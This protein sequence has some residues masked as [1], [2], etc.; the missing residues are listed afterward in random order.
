MKTQILQLEAHDDVISILDKIGWAQTE[1]VLLVLPPRKRVLAT[2]LDLLRLKRHTQ[3]RG[4][5]L[6]FV[7]NDSLVKALAK[8]VK[9][10]CYRTIQK[11]HQAD[12]NKEQID[13]SKPI[14]DPPSKKLPLSEQIEVI[15]TLRARDLANNTPFWARMLWFGLAVISVLSILAVLIPSASIRLKPPTQQQTMLLPMVATYRVQQAR[16]S[17]EIP[18]STRSVTVEGTKTSKVS[19]TIRLPKDFATGEVILTNLTDQ[20]IEVPKGT[21][22]R[23]LDQKPRRY[24]T[25]E[26]VTLEDGNQKSVTVLVQAFQAGESE[27][28][29]P[30]E[31]RA[32]EGLLGLKI[33]VENPQ[34]ILGGSSIN[35]PAPNERD[36]QLLF[37]QLQTELIH[38][39]KETI[40]QQI[41]ADDLLLPDSAIQTRVVRQEYSPA[42]NTAADFLSLELELEVTFGIIT[43]ESLEDLGSLIL[44]SSLPQGYVPLADTFSA[45]CQDSMIEMEGGD[46]TCTLKLSRELQQ[47]INPEEVRAHVVGKPRVTALEVLQHIYTLSKPAVIECFPDWFPLLPWLP[48]RIQILIER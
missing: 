27:N 2:K 7:T 46:Y 39:A 22:L 1:R 38:T 16:L 47:A 10:P 21:I 26:T 33:S 13:E 14:A 11:A 43:K 36:R 30:N 41:Q 17:G 3:S 32:V 31:I 8:E 37:R 45:S 23:T 5:Q 18:I 20:P 34:P 35:A 24:A 12:W 19:G 44:S 40:R 25:Q 15:Q 29:Q 28:A 9:I 42:E 6:A 4:C 48:M